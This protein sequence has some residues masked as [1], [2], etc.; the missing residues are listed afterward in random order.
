MSRRAPPAAPDHDRSRDRDR[1]HAV[2]DRFARCRVAV[3]GDFVADEFVYGRVSRISREAPVL[4][5]EYDRTDSRPGGAGNAANNVAA[6]GAKTRAV[7]LL[8]DDATGDRLR[9]A[10]HAGV[11]ARRAGPRPRPRDADQDAHPGRRHPFRQA[12]DRPDGSRHAPPRLR[13]RAAPLRS[14][15]AGR[16]RVDRR[17]ARLGL[18]RRPGD[19]ARSSPPSSGRRGRRTAGGRRSSS[20]RATTWRATA[21]SPRRRRTKPRP[22]R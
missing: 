1:L 16:D 7:G 19:A 10:L 5:L 3:I 15:G 13:R 20:T 18:R 8:G 22:R 2:I 6:L 21:G 9:A 12:A 14:G 11:D 4:I 17:R